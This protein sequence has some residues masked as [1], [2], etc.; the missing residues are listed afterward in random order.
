MG[1]QSAWF[2]Q[3]VK[4]GTHLFLGIRDPVSWPIVLPLDD[5]SGRGRPTIG[6]PDEA[7]CIVTEAHTLLAV[8]GDYGQRR[9]FLFPPGGTRALNRCISRI[10]DRT[11]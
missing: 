1:W 9:R 10:L 11:P 3:Y 6:P 5:P 8:S 4:V 7:G 2:D